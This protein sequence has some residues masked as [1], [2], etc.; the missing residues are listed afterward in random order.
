MA[1]AANH[2]NAIKGMIKEWYDKNNKTTLPPDLA[3]LAL[4]AGI[5]PADIIPSCPTTPRKGKRK[6]AATPSTRDGAVKGS[7]SGRC[8]VL[9]GVW[10]KLEEEAGMRSGKER[11][12]SRIERFGGKVTLAISGLTDALIIGE[13][14]GDKKLTQ[15]HKKEVKVIDITTLNC[16]ITGE[17][18]LDEVQTKYASAQ[19]A[20]VQTENHPVQRQ[21]QTHIPTEQAA[22][23]TAGQGGVQEIGHSDE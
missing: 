9:S 11:V 21:S 18:S 5:N 16:L 17:L 22:A 4:R 19:G 10:P 12:K 8:F 23:S 20:L 3:A 2:A 15:A 6:K 13:K 7:L 1:T 14:L